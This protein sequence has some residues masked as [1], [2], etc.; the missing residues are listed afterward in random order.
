MPFYVY[1]CPSTMEDEG[2]Y[3]LLCVS[4][5]REHAESVVASMTALSSWHTYEITTEKKEPK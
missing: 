2:R 1:E 3:T 4:P 5:T